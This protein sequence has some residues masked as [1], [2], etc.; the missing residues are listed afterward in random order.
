MNARAAYDRGIMP[1]VTSSRPSPSSN[2]WVRKLFHERTTSK[3]S[4]Q[5]LETLA[6]AYK[7]PVTAPRLPDPR[8]QQQL[9]RPPDAH[10]AEVDQDGRA[11]AGRRR[12]FIRHDW[13]FLDRFGLNDIADLP[14]VEELSDALGFELPPGLAEPT[15]TTSPLPFDAEEDACVEPRPCQ[16][17]TTTVH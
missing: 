12:P 8:R 16:P 9:G 5:S 7:Q 6:V 15:V 11:E 10:R 14:K 4:V 3:L 13:E 17:R 1:A 2:E